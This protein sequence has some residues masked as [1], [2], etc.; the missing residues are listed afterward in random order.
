MDFGYVSML[1]LYA[2]TR[3][4]EVTHEYSLGNLHTYRL[5]LF[6]FKSNT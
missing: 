3:F 5:C 2:M 1:P 4:C 6:Y